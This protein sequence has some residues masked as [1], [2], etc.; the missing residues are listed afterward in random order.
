MTED[1]SMVK[2]DQCLQLCSSWRQPL[3]VVAA[4]TAKGMNHLLIALKTSGLQPASLESMSLISLTMTTP[5]MKNMS[6]LARNV[7]YSQ[8]C[9]RIGKTLGEND[10]LK[11]DNVNPKTKTVRTPEKYIN[12]Q[13]RVVKTILEKSK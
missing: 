3:L 13:K 1:K 9:M 5:T 7:I 6:V 11:W 12:Q 2:S 4:I 8:M 10:V